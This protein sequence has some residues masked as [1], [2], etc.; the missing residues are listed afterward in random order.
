MFHG[1]SDSSWPDWLAL[2][3]SIKANVPYKVRSPIRESQFFEPT[4]PPNPNAHK[5]RR[6]ERWRY[7][8]MALARGGWD[9]AHVRTEQ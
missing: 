5:V 6:G 1:P 8:I 7:P 4:F 9:K 2:W 3:G